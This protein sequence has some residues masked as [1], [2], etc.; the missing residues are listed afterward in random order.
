MTESLYTARMG[1]VRRS[2]VAAIVSLVVWVAAFGS[3]AT[4]HT[5]RTG[6]A[7]CGTWEL[8]FSPNPFAE[9]LLHGVAAV[10]ATDAW[11]VGYGFFEFGPNHGPIIEHWD[12]TR[13]TRIGIPDDASLQ[14]VDA[15]SSDDVWA[16]GFSALVTTDPF[17]E[18]WDGSTWS[19]VPVPNPAQNAELLSVHALAT[20]DVWAVGWQSGPG[21]ETR[22]LTEHWDGSSWAV[23]P[24]PSPGSDKLHGV[25]GTSSADVW[26]VGETS[27]F[28]LIEHWDGTRW[29][30][31]RS[32]RPDRESTLNGVA[33]ISATDAWA[34]GFTG[35]TPDRAFAEQWSADGKWHWPNQ[36]RPHYQLQAVAGSSDDVWMVGIAGI[37]ALVEHWDG[38]SFAVVPVD[39]WSDWSSLEAVDVL[40]SGEAWAVGWYYSDSGPR[41]TETMHLAPC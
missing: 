1:L 31:V 39:G 19:A 21:I 10:S 11:A 15:V 2:W 33:A 4:A 41:F 38:A 29:S 5:G 25:S 34:V 16:V 32:F 7:G 17:A 12:G 36:P 8:V 20:D 9:D 13:W 3:V 28:P 24:S 18:H 22:T 6:P 26:A 35:I 30:I 40:P 23:V 14:D 37:E 27:S